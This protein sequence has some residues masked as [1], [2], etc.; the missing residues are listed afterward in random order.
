MR[1]IS[2]DCNPTPSFEPCAKKVSLLK[3]DSFSRV[4]KNVPLF[5]VKSLD[6]TQDTSASSEA[7]EEKEDVILIRDYRQGNDVMTV[8]FFI[9]IHHFD[10]N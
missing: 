4:F 6:R 10:S 9:Q 8:A 3:C 5:Q 2:K 1:F 7:K